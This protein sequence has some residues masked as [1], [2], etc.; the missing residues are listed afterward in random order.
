MEA[1]QA[2]AEDLRWKTVQRQMAIYGNAPH[3]LIQVLHTVQNAYGYLNAGIL[4]RVAQTLHLPLSRVYGVATFYHH[5]NLTPPGKN[6]C[7]VCTGTT[8]FI[9]GG[10]GILRAVEAE[11]GIKLGETTSDGS[12]TLLTARCLGACSLAPVA[13]VNGRVLSKL[14][15]ELLL[16]HLK[17]VVSHVQ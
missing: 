7:I 1:N 2:N 8:C 5:F 16:T 12:L 4:A 9:K 17:G 3:A 11:Y 13:I 14:T 10:E 6:L 15:P